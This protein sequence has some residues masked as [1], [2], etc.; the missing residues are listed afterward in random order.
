MPGPALQIWSFLE[1]ARQAETRFFGFEQC[2][3]LLAE[4]GQHKEEFHGVSEIGEFPESW[5]TELPE[6]E[7][8][9]SEG[10]E[11]RASS[12]AYQR[13]S[14]EYDGFNVAV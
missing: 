7:S 8:R 10:L 1:E 12:G 9:S 11:L 13:G 5:Y 6:H 3:C 14:E 4:T 2:L